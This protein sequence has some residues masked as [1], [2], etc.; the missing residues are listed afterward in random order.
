MS[1]VLD[2][3]LSYM[4]DNYISIKVRCHYNLATYVYVS[5]SSLCSSL[6]TCVSEFKKCDQ[7]N[8]PALSYHEH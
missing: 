3:D 6:C 4:H 1:L 5:S 2:L 7:N 8:L